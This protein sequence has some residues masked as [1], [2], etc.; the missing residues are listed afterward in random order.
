[1]DNIIIASII[2]L[3]I[4]IVVGIICYT[5]YKNKEDSDANKFFKTVNYISKEQR[6]IMKEITVIKDEIATIQKSIT[7]LSEQINFINK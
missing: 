1:M 5:D 2:C 6:E 3:S 7:F 4:I